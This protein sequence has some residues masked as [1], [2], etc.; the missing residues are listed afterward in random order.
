MA[1]GVASAGAQAPDLTK[2]PD[3][4][5]QWRRPPGVGIQFDQSKPLGLRQGAPLT[6][7]YQKIYEAGLAD[8]AAG[9]QAPTYRC[10]PFGMPRMITSCSIL[11]M[12]RPP[13]SSPTTGS[14]AASLPT[15]AFRRSS[16]RITTAIPS[17]MVDTDGDGKYDEL[18]VETRHVRPRS[19]EASGIP[20]TRTTRPS[21]ERLYLDKAT[22]TS[23]TTT[24]RDNNVDASLRSP[25]NTCA[26]RVPWSG[27]TDCSEDNH[28]VLIGKENHFGGDG[29]LM[30][31][32]RTN[33]NP[34]CVISIKRRGSDGFN[35]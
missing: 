32:K 33:Q 7:E 23:S 14:R 12:P 4:S 1:V 3:W 17:A 19:F 35:M 15:G 31:T 22:R 21:W 16:S 26:R 24:H 20:R 8:R 9:G 2:Y 29:M 6:P 5:G 28:Q 18:R 27:T 30:P 13:T 10:I 25:R 34:I 11:I